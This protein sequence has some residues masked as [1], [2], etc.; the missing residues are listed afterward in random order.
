MSVR[1]IQ[2]AT[3]VLGRTCEAPLGRIWAAFSEP[4][5]RARLGAAGAT[6]TV[7]VERA[8]FLVGSSE[9]HRFGSRS[10]PR[11]HGEIIYHDIVPEGRIVA[12]EFTREGDVLLSVAL[13]AL[14]FRASGDQTHLKATTQTMYLGEPEGCTDLSSRY[15]ILFGNFDAYLGLPPRLRGRSLRR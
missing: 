14:E 5:E 1:T 8:D 12:T 7:A 6:M 4:T 9:R 10:Q 2:H 3:F 13:T 15:E 11:F